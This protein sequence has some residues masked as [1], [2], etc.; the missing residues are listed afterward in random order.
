MTG[1]TEAGIA[2]YSTSFD[3]ALPAGYDIPLSFVFA[4]TTMN[5]TVADF[6]AQLFVNGY[7]FGK[8][9]KSCLP[10]LA[11]LQRPFLA[12]SAVPQFKALPPTHLRFL[13]PCRILSR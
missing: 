5:G 7:Q 12:S 3:L 4:N 6:R 11:L 1:I 2:F 10:V 8:Y 9:G 13:S